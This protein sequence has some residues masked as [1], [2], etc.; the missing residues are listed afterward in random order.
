MYSVGCEEVQELERTVGDLQLSV[1]Q[2]FFRIRMTQVFGGNWVSQVRGVV[3]GKFAGTDAHKQNYQGIYDVLSNEGVETLDETRM[4]ITAMTA[5]MLYDFYNQCKVGTNFRQQI[6][7]IQTD[8]NRLVSHISNPNDTL[9][10]KILELT[11]L[12]DIRS[13]LKYLRNSTWAYTEKQEFVDKYQAQI[14]GISK[15]I[16][17]EVAGHDRETVE[18][19]SNRRNYLARIAGERAENAAEYIPLSY[20]ADDGTSQRFDLDELYSLGNNANGFVLFSK[21]AGYGKTWSIQELAGQCAA[22]ALNEADEKAE[23]SENHEESEGREKSEKYGR[24]TPI[25]IRMGELAVSEE[26]IMKAVQEIFYPGEDGLEK[27]R[28]FVGQESVVLFI[29][30]M[31]EANKENKEAAWRELNKLSSSA[32]DVR[33]IGGTRESDKQWYPAELPRYSICDL[34]DKQVEAFIDKLVVDEEQRLTAKYDY[35]ENPRTGFLKNLRSPFYLKCFIEFVKEGESGPDSDTD[36]MNRCINKM[37][38]R[39]IGLKGFRATVQIV[40]EYLAKLSELIGNDKR[41]VP[42]Q[43]ALK[44]IKDGLM[45]DDENYASV[46]QIKDTLVELQILKEVIRERQPAL[47]GFWHEKYKSLFSPI[48]LDTSLWDY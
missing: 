28:K 25:L 17:Q 30:G 8:K 38:E 3:E 24:R 29:D 36:M 26:P 42:E 46:V 23:E 44:K 13:F 10:V 22:R 19:E 31:D 37:I 6:R 9:N 33:V 43:E 1:M 35:F 47:L 34:T 45:Y 15:S 41:Y 27:A 7:N 14:E 39:E 4:D 12:K 16:F 32:K 20:K 11:A 5:L 40:N 48:A 2:E 18:F 21:E